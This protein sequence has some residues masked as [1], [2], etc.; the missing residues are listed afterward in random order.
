MDVEGEMNESWVHYESQTAFALLN[1]GSG[2]H[3]L[4]ITDG[5]VVAVLEKGLKVGF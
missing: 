1:D 3:V 4:V 2:E 5:G